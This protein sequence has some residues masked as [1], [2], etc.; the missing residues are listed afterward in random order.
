MGFTPFRDQFENR[1]EVVKMGEKITQQIIDQY[2]GDPSKFIVIIRPEVSLAEKIK[3]NI[4]YEEIKEEKKLER[5]L[6]KVGA[7][8][9]LF[10]QGDTD[11]TIYIL[12]EGE[13]EILVNGI[14][15]AEIKEKG[16]FIG[17]MSIVRGEV[18]S[19]S[20]KARTDCVFYSVDGSDLLTL[21]ENH[22]VVLSKL[23]QS[24]ANKV[25]HTST[26]L[27]VLKMFGN[28]DKTRIIYKPIHDD[29]H[30]VENVGQYKNKI[31]KI[32]KG[33]NLFVE[34]EMSFDLFILV[35]GE[36]RVSIGGE[37]IV[38]ISS[39]G[40]IIGEMASLRVMPRSATVTTVVASEFYRIQGLRLMDT[41][42]E[43]PQLLIKL[44]QILANRLA[45][46]SV[47]FAHL[48]K[49]SDV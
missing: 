28:A 8:E 9:F 18:R 32:D 38:R 40:I 29:S 35:K 17:E 12:M 47:E 4:E 36:V 34:G 44:A 10:V 14:Q 33:V 11:K 48:V 3:F 1:R 21:A 20:V 23:C 25:A 37:A 7:G 19:A 5:I 41:C 27:S 46:T 24:L 16:C 30:F 42:K 39:P 43:D 6:K 45:I 22:P 2:K 49:S 15:V 26:E 31:H 13:V